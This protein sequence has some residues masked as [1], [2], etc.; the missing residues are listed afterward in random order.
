MY[1][2][3]RVWDALGGPVLF[4]FW[5]GRVFVCSF[6]APPLAFL[7]V[8]AAHNII[9]LNLR[10]LQWCWLISGTARELGR[11][12]EPS[13]RDSLVADEEW[14]VVYLYFSL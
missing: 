9:I 6:K 2:S 10:L 11:A 1:M 12:Q 8:I 7:E 3:S 13:V 5:I 4:W 14:Q